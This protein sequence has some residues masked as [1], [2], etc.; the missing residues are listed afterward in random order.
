MT[1]HAF[2]D[3]ALGRL[4]AVGVA[5]VEVGLEN[6]PD[7]LDRSGFAGGNRIGGFSA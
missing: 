1:V 2:G 7:L 4:D 6:D 5:D 3:D